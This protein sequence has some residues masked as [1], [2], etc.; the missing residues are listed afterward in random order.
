M[1]RINGGRTARIGVAPVPALILGALAL[2]GC[3]MSD[4]KAAALLVAPGGYDFY[5]CPQLAVA[6]SG[7]R[8]RRQ[9]L[10]SLMA[11]ANVD[12]GGRMMSAIGYRPEYLK[13]RGQLHEMERTAR[14]KQCDLNAVPRTAGAPT[15]APAAPPA[16][17]QLVVPAPGR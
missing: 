7:L 10:E 5:S 11:R 8:T 12:A 14:E 6:A 1:T 17:G 4:D 16:P 15:G 3:A 13:I 9:E 2:G